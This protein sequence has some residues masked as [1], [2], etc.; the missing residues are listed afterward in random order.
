MTGGPTL[1]FT[2]TRAPWV[3]VGTLGGIHAN[4]FHGPRVALSIGVVSA[5]LATFAFRRVAR[6]RPWAVPVGI[7]A[8]MTVAP[9]ALAAMTEARQ[10]RVSV[11]FW[12]DAEVRALF[13]ASLRAAPRAFRFFLHGAALKDCRP[14]AWS[15][16]S[17]SDCALPPNLAVNVPQTGWATRCGIVRR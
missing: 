16:R 4:H 17:M 12:A 5:L 6:A 2:A 9:L 7:T 15:Y 8:L 14:H 1:V 10:A 11:A 3:G 13:P